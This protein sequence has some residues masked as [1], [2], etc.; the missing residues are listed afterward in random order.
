MEFILI[1]VGIAAL[2]IMSRM[3][4]DIEGLKS[5]LDLI[6][7]SLRQKRLSTE[8]REQAPDYT[9]PF[10]PGPS[11]PA[12]STPPETVAQY[13]AAVEQEARAK[14][15]PDPES[16][17]AFYFPADDDHPAPARSAS[18]KDEKSGFEMQFGA[19]LP[20]WGGGIAL[21]LAGFFLVKYSIEMGWLSPAVRLVIG[22]VFGFALLLAGDRV[23]KK[24]DMA[25]GTRIAQALSGAGVADLY[26]C[27]YA[28]TELYHFLNPALGFLAMAAVTATAVLLSL[29]HGPPIA[30]LGMAG[31][32]LTPALIVSGHHSA[33]LLFGYLYLVLAGLMT[34]IRREG[35]WQLGL[36]A[37]FG[38]FCWVVGWLAGGLFMPGDGIWLGLFLLA[39]CITVLALSSAGQEDKT[40]QAYAM[41]LNYFTAVGALVLMGFV[42]G[43]A[44]FG[45]TEWGL[46]GLMAA[47]AIALAWFR[48]EIYKLMPWFA[49]A[50]NAMMLAVWRTSDTQMYA[51]VLAAFA[52][53]YVVSGWLL[54]WRS[55]APLQWAGQAVAAG[56]GF[57]LLGWFRLHEHF[58]APYTWSGIA[59]AAALACTH[60]AAVILR[61]FGDDHPQ[62]Q[63]LLAVYAAAA[64]GFVSCALTIE[65]KHEFLSVAVAMEALALAWISSRVNVT[66]LRRIAGFVA[67]GFGVL[68]IPQAIL[69]CELST[70]S[71]FEVKLHAD[72]KLPAVQWPLFQL[73]LPA[74]SFLGAAYFLRKTGD[75]G[76]VRAFEVVSV[77]LTALAGYYTARHLMHPGENILF[78][79][80]GF[81]EHGAIT[82]AL[83]AFGLG[84]TAAGRRFGRSAITSSGIAT[85]AVAVFRVVYF[86]LLIHNPLW[87]ESQSV[88]ATPVFNALPLTYGLPV[89]VLWRLTPMLK[90]GWQTASRALMLLLSF[91]LVTFEVRQAYHGAILAK[92]STGNGEIYAYSAAWLVFGLVLLFLGTLR[93][94]KMMRVAS[95]GVMILTV[96]KVFLYDAAALAGLYRVFSFL[97]LGLCLLGLSWFYS[98]FV[99]PKA[100]AKGE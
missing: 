83:L 62:K 67:L 12:F 10:E 39:T 6:E 73:G 14:A 44:D 95:L 40:V 61:D 100:P 99:F 17:P 3:R 35:W 77:V 25:D 19:R 92:G 11:S 70:Y 57:Y 33:F 87:A 1:L 72:A 89:L 55:R 15:A 56:T 38:V 69:L 86:D 20:V 34:V 60:A 4:T 54:Q 43:K 27:A 91:V 80:A 49:L 22:T 74:L 82:A 36:V 97:G 53:L 47:G 68:L 46:S 48:Q 51:S 26:A 24:P 66:A 2:I 75:S 21:A 96:G 29:R 32:Y 13:R 98:R 88:G 18:R 28:A 37:V 50:A 93:K 16:E 45:L 76:Q 94:N 9:P 65:L 78:V 64:T 59:V 7:S 63:H 58:N 31:G 71:L 23:R 85:C 41:P 90:D 81:A 8:A 5:R 42:S 79:K 30:L 84:C 52:V